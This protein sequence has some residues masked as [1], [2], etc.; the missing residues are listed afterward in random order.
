MP[1]PR[2]LAL[3]CIRIVPFPFASP[4]FPGQHLIFDSTP[5]ASPGESCFEVFRRCPLC[6]KT[7]K[8]HRG[9]WQGGARTATATKVSPN[10]RQEP[11]RQ[12]TP[13]S[14]ENMRDRAAPRVPQVSPEQLPSAARQRSSRRGGIAP[15]QPREDGAL[16][17][18]PASAPRLRKMADTLAAARLLC[19]EDM[20]RL[21]I[22]PAAAHAEATGQVL[23]FSPDSLPSPPP[24]NPHSLLFALPAFPFSL[25]PPI[26]SPLHLHPRPTGRHSAFLEFS[27]A[28]RLFHLPPN[29]SLPPKYGRSL[30]AIVYPPRCC[31]LFAL[32][33]P[34][35]VMFYQGHG[36]VQSSGPL[37]RAGAAQ[38]PLRLL[39]PWQKPTRLFCLRAAGFG[40][41][42]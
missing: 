7:S 6:P 37:G 33:L 31:M 3:H 15:P 30:G 20:G 41:R 26:H 27:A 16:Y 35:R 9:S 40:S 14:G 19:L 1:T 8:V 13:P 39:P 11:P 2:Y 38:L 18:A 10:G 36:E 5:L 12:L 29:P 25:S 34:Q 28:V 17:P 42:G 4:L 21:N 32:C 23:P 24:L 22:S